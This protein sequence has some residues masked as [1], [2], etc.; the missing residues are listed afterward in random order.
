MDNIYETFI[1][2]DDKII[3]PVL[4]NNNIL[5]KHEDIGTIF[6]SVGLKNIKINNYKIY[7]KSFIHKSYM[8]KTDFIKNEKYFG[9]ID[10]L[11]IE[12]HPQLLPLQEES[13]EVL[14]WL[15]DAMLQSISALYLYKRFGLS[16]NEGFLTKIR[17]K[18]VKTETLSKLSSIVEFNKYMII[19]KH[20]EKICEGRT[21]ERILEDCFESFIGA[22][23]IDQ[24]HENPGNAIN[25]I[26]EFM[27]NIIENNIDLTEFIINDDNYKDQLM[28]Y[29]H[30]EFN[31]TFP[32][33]NLINN[34][35]IVND[36]ITTRKFTIQIKDTSNNI[37]STGVGK[38]KKD[39]EQKAAQQALQY[40]GI[41]NNFMYDS[42]LSMKTNNKNNFNYKN[43]QDEST[44]LGVLNENNHII[45]EHDIQEI[46]NQ[47]KLNYIKPINIKYYQQAFIHKS[48][49]ETTDFEK[50]KKLYGNLDIIQESSFKILPL[51]AES[52]EVLEWIGDA[53]LQ[54]VS[55]LYLYRRYGI[56]QKEGFLTRIRSKIVKTESLSKLASAL[57]MDKHLI[58]SKHFDVVLLGRNNNRI[59]EDCFESFLGA[60]LLDF[61]DNLTHLDKAFNIIYDFFKNAVENN[62]NLSDIILNDDN[63]KDQLMR[64]F[65][66][67]FDGQLPTYELV[68]SETT[69]TSDGKIF[70]KFTVCI[71][72]TNNNVIGK[73]FAKS[74]KDAE[75][76]AAQYALQ[77]YGI[78]NGY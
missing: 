45:N 6:Q 34:E 16:Q 57:Q 22:I 54:S 62:I 44:L 65:H 28:R 41:N 77:Y 69:N 29:F 13:N 39:A 24:G 35:I 10:G 76:R 49:V 2:K 37:I 72:D 31:G 36:G 70:H 42:S 71:Y 19:S 27:A 51:Q 74:K 3:Y 20:V 14:E 48:Y 11:H 67:E 17:S 68:N 25:I 30:K 23:M 63:Y 5:I 26:Y 53:V 4:N 21:N 59:L 9:N 75:Q 40:F 61:S 43:N 50:N 32:I 66:K 15:G 47:L 55:G 52:N 78:F 33:Y 56:D 12:D 60:M 73:A 64:Y 38:S 8:S 7:Q 46:F 58:M 1:I 18:I